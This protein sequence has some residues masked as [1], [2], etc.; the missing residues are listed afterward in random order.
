MLPLVAAEIYD[1]RPDLRL[2]YPD[3]HTSASPHGFWR[4]F[5]RHGYE[6]YDIRILIDRFRRS[7]LCGPTYRFA[8]TVIAALGDTTLQFLGQDRMLAAG[9]LRAALRDDLAN[10]LLE[11]SEEWF[12]FTDLDS[13]LQTYSKRP[14]LQ[15]AFPDIIGADFPRYLTWVDRHAVDEHG[16]SPTAA[17]ALSQHRPLACLA[18]IFSYLSRR[19]DLAHACENSLLSDDPGP[20]LRELIRA[21][22]ERV[23]FDLDDVVM[24]RFIHQNSRHLLVPLYLE[25]PSVRRAPVASRVAGSNL[26]ALPESVRGMAWARRGAKLHASFFDPFEAKL[27]AE[28]RRV[29][30]GLASAPS[31]VFGLLPARRGITQ[32]FDLVEALYP[33]VEGR[34]PHDEAAERSARAR[35]AERKSL[36]SVNLFGYFHSDIGLGESAR[37]LERA[38]AL[39]RPVSR[40]PLCT[41]Q[42]CEGT[43]LA[44]LF[45]RFDYLAD[46]NVFV[47]YPHQIEDL[48]GRTALEQRAGRRNVAHLAWEQKD[49]NPLWKSVYDRY[50]E[51]WTISGFAA[52]AFRRMFP[53][54][55]RVV[56]NVVNFEDFPPC[57]DA[58]RRR[59]QGE[60]LNFLFVFDANSS[61]ERKNPEGVLD[62]FIK[63]FKGTPRAGQVRLT[64]KIGGMYRP[65]HSARVERLMVAAQQSGLAI[66]F[67]G[68]QLARNALL[69]LIAG[70]DCYVSLHRAEG[71]GYTMAEAMFYGVPV[72]ASAYSGNLQFMRPAT[73]SWFRAA[74]PS[75]KRRT[76]RS[77]AGRFGP[78]QTSMWPSR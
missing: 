40:L 24:L 54:R 50:D 38:L 31:D 12:F 36:P 48:L 33:K 37:G 35:L 27:E 2:A 70:A 45:Q 13:L 78:N 4:W 23:D 30:A 19:D 58:A 72:I 57:E 9:R 65:E 67:D 32:S 62:A 29:G 44:D 63:A 46:T 10:A 74:K 1:A 43:E 68:R 34:P 60:Q 49:S 47:S 69:Q 52:T 16:C 71:F 26:A 73:A 15:K 22:G 59:L 17:K 14:D 21:A 6:E 39:L 3:A 25:L 66:S 75:S 56:P 5:C 7:L 61:M 11:T 51:I 55:V 42:L 77:N 8:E 53:G 41:T 18:R 20:I 64:L 76:A 28:M